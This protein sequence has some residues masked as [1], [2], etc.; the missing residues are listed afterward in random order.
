MMKAGATQPLLSIVIPTH[1]RARYALPTVRSL[2]ETLP[3]EVELVVADT[4]VG[5]SLT[6]AL[7]ALP[8]AARVRLVRPGHGLS[9]VDNFNAGL[10]HARGEFVLFLGD[11][12]FVLPD[13]VPL[14]K[15]ALCRGVDALKF[16]F[17]ALYH[18]PDF[19]HKRRGA[20]FAGTLHLSGFSGAIRPHD[21]V[22]ALRAAAR[23]L[24]GGVG[25]MP[26]VYAGV[27]SRGLLDRIL[28]KHGALFGGVSPDIYSA[29]LIASESRHCVYIDYPVVVPGSSGA[30]TAGQSAQGRHVGSLRNNAHIAPF[31]NLVW[32][33]VVPEFYSV[34]TV[35]SY[36]LLAALERVPGM[37]QPAMGRLMARCLFYHRHY[38]AETLRSLGNWRRTAG[39][40]TTGL[41]LAR[42]MGSELVWIGGKLRT[43][44]LQRVAP[45]RSTVLNGL[46][47]TQAASA[48][49]S[50][51][52]S[53]CPT[54]LQ[55][56][57]ALSAQ[58]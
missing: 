23:D 31:Q 2:L 42:G 33:P 49:L 12:D 29:T 40:L 1:E 5:D 11:D 32:N 34:P 56:W 25:E 10:A 20:T 8:Q 9:V 53:A 24:G 36:S 22:A 45:R 14:L 27:V 15:E 13:V 39:L 43:L 55:P 47:D 4:S 21:P 26:R 17:P 3:V 50:A 28:A 6:Q 44:A 52:L 41:E 51:W 16:S 7:Q 18:W 30:S 54:R 38:R 19:M 35:W 48:A 58:R 46:A 37:A 57:P